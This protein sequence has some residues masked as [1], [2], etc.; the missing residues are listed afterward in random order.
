MRTADLDFHLPG[1]LIASHP[2]PE[3]AAARLLVV[4][5][6]QGSWEHRR[7][8]DLPEL[9]RPGDLLVLNDT[10]VVPARIVARKATGGRVEGLWLE[11][12]GGGLALCM[13]S[14]G[15]LRPGTELLLPNGP[16]RLRLES[17]I[18]PGRWLVEDADRVG[19]LRLLAAAGATPL[20]PYIL[21]RRRRGAEA[22]DSPEDRERYQTVF[23]RAEGSVAAPTASL[24]FDDELLH[25]IAAR[26]VETAFLTLHVGS[27]TFEPIR[28][29][30]VEDHWTDAEP[31]SVP[32]STLGA[33]HR[34]RA[35][36]GRILAAG[37][38][39]CRV[40]EHL[41]RSGD[42]PDDPPAA[43][44]R[45]GTTDLFITP[46]SRFLW[47]GALLTNFHVPRSTP[48]ALVAAF[49]AHAGAPDGLDLVQRA[50]AAAVEQEYRFFSYGDASLWL[51]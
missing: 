1:H 29:D 49:A 27:A 34:T 33:L 10:R 4:H 41:A 5:C 9:L 19:W 14:G 6:R 23:A 11:E 3:R 22:E 50:Y 12:R 26:G 31:Y 21:E 2:P 13:L 32:G 43:S 30:R 24:H 16:Y 28:T 18:A 35:H 40:L 37:T 36:G 48:L 15:R 38:T 8:R 44:G 7:F 46:G 20:P 25:A 17:R 39:A 45:R 47:T 42:G 51:P